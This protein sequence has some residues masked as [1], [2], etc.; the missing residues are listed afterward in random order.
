MQSG[1]ALR[2]SVTSRPDTEKKVQESMSDVSHRPLFNRIAVIGVGL[3]G[4]SLA[5]ACRDGIASRVIGLDVDQTHLQQAL[6]LG[7]V[8]Q[9]DDLP[10][11]VEGA[12]LV[13][14]AVPVGA[15]V[16]VVRA[17]AP[18]LAAESIVT[19]VGSVKGDLV[20]EVEEEIP[21][22]RT[23]V[24]GHPI[25]GT[26]RSGPEASRAGLFQNSLCVL[27]PTSRTPAEALGKVTHLWETLGSKVVRMDPFQ[28]DRIFALVSHLPHVVA[29]TLMATLLSP[30]E[31]GEELLGF[32]AGGLRD[33][34]RIAASDPV[35]WRDILIRNRK[36]VLES[37]ARF[38]KALTRLEEMIRTQDAAG[39]MEEF[40]R[41]KE[42]REQLR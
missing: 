12:D 36:E 15:I 6:S 40:Q 22:G 9:A 19:D 23:Y 28:H 13:V 21:A 33:F 4:G 24:G 32:S 30:T 26:E 34:T 3:I 11:G 18:H 17:I 35:M 14:V 37:I 16:R 5:R 39:L 42:I 27:T 41:A 2:A 25:T 20:A 38:Q 8:N 29:Y 10:T 1:I 7:L 31:E